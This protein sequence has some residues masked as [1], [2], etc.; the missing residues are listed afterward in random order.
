MRVSSSV[1]VRTWTAAFLNIEPGSNDPPLVGQ[2]Y[3]LRAMNVLTLNIHVYSHMSTGWMVYFLF[4]VI[5][6][7][8]QGLPPPITDSCQ[9]GV[10]PAERS[11][12][13]FYRTTPDIESNTCAHFEFTTDGMS[14][15]LF[16][17]NY[18]CLDIF[19]CL[20]KLSFFNIGPLFVRRLFSKKYS[21][22]CT[23]T[24]KKKKSP[25]KK[26]P[27]ML[28]FK[29]IKKITKNENISAVS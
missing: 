18:P 2:R 9:T 6:L 7:Q 25:K 28:C 13:Q 3:V 10:C 11:R 8:H 23:Q 29:K 1:A 14:N 24:I 17:L 22:Q 16:P 21:L 12:F 4:F 19:H 26:K 20:S 27:E 5:F 15:K